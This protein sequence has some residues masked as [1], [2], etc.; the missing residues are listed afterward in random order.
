MTEPIAIVGIGCRFPGGV[1]RPGALWDLLVEGRDVIRPIARDGIEL[2][3]FY[4]PEPRTPGRMMT[5]WGGFLEDLERFDAAFFGIS[6]REAASVDPAQRL[7]LEATWEAFEDATIDPRSVTG[8]HVGVFVGQWLSDFESRLFADTE[9][10]DFHA[11]TGSGRYATSGRVSFVL[12][13]VGPSITVDTACS[14][15]LVAVHLACQSLRAGESS[16]AVAAGVNVILQP[17]ISI[18]YSQSG[19]MA[20]DGHCKF[21]DA[22]GD[23]YVR[24]EGVGVVVLK[25]LA[26]ALADGDPVRA[27]IRG[28]AV[29]NDGRGSGH[30]ATPSRT[31]QAAMLRTAYANAGVDPRGVGYVEAHGTGTRAGDP[32]ELGAL[33]DVLASG[34]GEDDR[35]LVGSVK[36]NIGHT[37]GAAGMAGL[38]KCVLSLEHEQVPA[39]LHLNVPNPTIPWD[40]LPFDIPQ[41]TTPWPRVADRP[42]IAGVSAFGITGTNAHVVIE[43]A[44]ESTPASVHPADRPMP[45]V[46]SAAAPD[47]LRDLAGRCADLLAGE[48][49]PSLRDVCATAARHR[50]AFRYRAV[51]VADDARAAAERLRLFAEGDDRAADITGEDDGAAPRRIAL[52]FPGQGGQWTGMARELLA[53]E[54]TFRATIERCDHALPLGLGWTVEEQLRA[55]P[56]TP[57][58]RL[59][60]ISVIQPVLLAVEIALAEQWRSWGVRP[61]AMVGHS[62]GEIG[63][64]CVAGALSIEEA[65]SVICTRSALMQHTSGSGAMAVIELPADAVADR[66]APYDGRVCIAVVNSPRSTVISGDTDAVAAVL[67]DC[68]RDDVF[69][70]SVKV[71]VASHSSQM[72]P[73]VPELIAALDRLTPDAASTTLYSTVDGGERPGDTWDAAY[74][75]SNLRRPVQFG[76]TIERMLGDGVDAFIEVGP[77]PTLLNAISQAGAAGRAPVAIGS[78]R[79]GAPE[80]A[81]LLASLGALWAA[82]HPVDWSAIFPTGSYA[83]VTL[84]SYPWQRERHWSAAALPISPDRAQRHRP[85]DEGVDQWMLV[86]RWDQIPS[87]EAESDT[88]PATG[89]RDWVLVGDDP[90]SM[91]ALCDALDDGTS[92]VR[93]AGSVEE[94]AASISSTADQRG[95]SVVILPSP[96]TEA[97]DPVAAVQ[98]FQRLSLDG[99]PGLTPRLWWVTRGAHVVADEAPASD[100]TEQAALWGAARVVAVEHPQWWG[101]LVDLDPADDWP[102]QAEA[103]AAHLRLGDDEDQVAIRDGL[104][105]GLRVVPA[106]LDGGVPALPHRWRADAAYLLTGGL[107]GVALEI[108]ASMVRDGARRLV[109]LG[110]SAMPPRSTWAG[111]DEGTEVGRR[112]SAVRALEHAGASVHLLH[113]DVADE[114]QLKAALA[115]Y[116][117]EGWPPIAG[118]IHAAAVVDSRLAADTDRECFD[119]VLVPKLHGAAVL[120]RLLPELDLFVV[121]SSFFSFWGFTGMANYAAANAGL[122]ALA[123]ARRQRGQ[124]ALSI[125]WGAWSNVGLHRRLDASK[126]FE[127]LERHGVSTFSADEGSQCFAALV[128]APVPVVAVVPIDWA[129]LRGASRVRDVPLFRAAPGAGEGVALPTDG[130]LER[131]RGAAPAERRVMVEQI[132]RETVTSVLRLP[133]GQLDSRRPF[134]SLG[135]DSLMALELRNRLEETLQLPLSASLAWNYPTVDVLT[136]HLDELFAPRSDVEPVEPAGSIEPAQ[137]VVPD[138][139]VD[140]HRLLDE[141]EELTDDDAARLLRGAR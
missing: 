1:D 121:F 88:A 89:G 66:I 69:A 137:P 127:E 136:A 128:N 56:G 71:D 140:L 81:S 13:T 34:R 109:L 110:R 67:A 101:G 130:L 83:R 39:S 98:T 65:M 105:Y 94:A 42:R 135:L 82:G 102:A 118:V 74:W 62:M 2:D 8:E 45:M 139:D 50:T 131:L 16:L 86:T 96:D 33:G 55:E 61:E 63:A 25:P 141:V 116:A 22:D 104:R 119:R 79:R 87:P 95:V 112:I 124:H 68:K 4:D 132:V 43:E 120:D 125:Q 17:S 47:A 18:A 40:E 37:E 32:V 30:M 134:G 77:H 38:I 15:S 52:V 114:S 113:A 23:G 70:R 76:P 19:M 51:F 11:T 122:D 111:V 85:L 5:R 3:R 41:R 27:V 12:G 100:C 92:I 54:P 9:Q 99:A 84:P 80:R 72:D 60:E 48:S 97:F 44:P 64:A 31:G 91:A 14:S 117:A 49:S 126:T 129:R 106:D 133:A 29:N 108:A 73:L 24:S 57:T 7:V 78:L 21:G 90:S 35:C 103:L 75:G 115:A 93:T 20:P 36:T 28:S 123:A 138:D 107:G 6:P 46:L 58:Y 26:A 59:D 53:N 10:I